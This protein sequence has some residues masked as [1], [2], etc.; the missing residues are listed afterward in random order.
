M[1]PSPPVTV[2]RELQSYM[3]A[4]PIIF[5][6]LGIWIVFRLS[7]FDNINQLSIYS[8]ELG[9]MI[10]SNVHPLRASY[11]IRLSS[12]IFTLPRSSASSVP[13][14]L[15]RIYLRSSLLILPVTVSLVMSI[16]SSHSASVIALAMTSLIVPMVSTLTVISKV[17]YVPR[18]PTI[19]GKLFH[20]PAFSYRL[21]QF[22]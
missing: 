21:K 1:I 20:P 10:V 3:N 16:I 7:Q 19:V 17:G 6:L 5:T 4:G 2:S 14:M 18:S 13:P 11:S 8:T 9:S 12:S 15:S 22:E